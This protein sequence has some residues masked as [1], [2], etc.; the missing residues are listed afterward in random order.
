MAEEMFCHIEMTYKVE[1]R[2]RYMVLF[3]SRE[4]PTQVKTLLQ[5]NMNSK[6]SLI[7]CFLSYYEL[8]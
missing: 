8:N 4:L 6:Q 5:A 2:C 3:I 1:E 7:E